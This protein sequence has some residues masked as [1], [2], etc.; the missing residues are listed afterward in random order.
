ME[1]GPESTASAGGEVSVSTR[2]LVRLILTSAVVFAL[3][4][5][6]TESFGEVAVDVDLKPFFLPY[7]MLATVRYG[8]PALSIGLGAALGEGVLD[9]FEGYELDDPIG[10]IGYVVGFMAFSWYLREVVSDP[11]RT[12]SQVVAA[13]LGGFVQAVFEGAAFLAF[14][15][16]AGLEQAAVSVLGNTVTHGLLLGAIPL[17]ALLSALRPRL[18]EILE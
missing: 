13:I 10:F 18:A 17:V 3:A 12:R 7:L 1:H 15:P 16:A 6:V 11:T 8:L 2:R 4:L 9:I 14:A 5:V